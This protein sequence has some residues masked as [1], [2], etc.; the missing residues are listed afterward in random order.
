MKYSVIIEPMG[1]VRMT[2]RGKWTSPQAKRYLTY[3]DLIRNQLNQQV[4]ELIE[5][6]CGVSVTFHMPIP[7]SWSLKKRLAAFGQPMQT[8]P[9]IDNLIKGLFDACNG[10]VWKDDNLVVSCKA[11][12]C[13]AVEAR[14]EFEVE[15]MA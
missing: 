2:Q 9:D 11:R 15:A 4:D 1:A 12:K 5:G 7:S 3:K 10:V 14:I 13:Y 8:K 6:A